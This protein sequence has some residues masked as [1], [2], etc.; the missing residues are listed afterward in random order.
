[1]KKIAFVLTLCVAVTFTACNDDE[2]PGEYADYLVARP[3]TLSIDEFKN[4][5]DILPPVPIEE[6]GKIYAY[7]D[8][9]FVNDTLSKPG[10]SMSG[11]A[12]ID[13]GSA[14]MRVPIS[15]RA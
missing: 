8:L 7:K 10:R 1:M 9:I 6:S 11:S 4:S 3:L 12:S 2:Q 15:G 5:V 14:L 13:Q